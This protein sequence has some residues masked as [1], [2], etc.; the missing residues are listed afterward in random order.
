MGE[1][2]SRTGELV[3]SYAK[4]ERLVGKLSTSQV[5]GRHSNALSISVFVSYWNIPLSIDWV[6]KYGVNISHVT[7]YL[8]VPQKER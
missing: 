8:K 7:F 2:C 4:T 1:I 3:Y 6:D 5:V